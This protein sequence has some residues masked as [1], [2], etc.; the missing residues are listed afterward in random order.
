[1][2]DFKFTHN[3]TMEERPTP[4]D[5]TMHDKVSLTYLDEDTII[6]IKGKGIDITLEVANI[7]QLNISRRKDAQC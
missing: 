6:H 3:L 7:N 4:D 5:L 1:M 2:N